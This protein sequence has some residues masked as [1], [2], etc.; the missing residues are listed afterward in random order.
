MAPSFPSI[1]SAHQRDRSTADVYDLSEAEP[2]DTFR[3]SS[4]DGDRDDEQAAYLISSRRQATSST[5]LLRLV[6][7]NKWIVFALIVGV[8]MGQSMRYSDV[9]AFGAVREALAKSVGAATGQEARG[10][11]VA[12]G[13]WEPVYGIEDLSRLGTHVPLKE[14]ALPECERTVLLNWV[15]PSPCLPPYASRSR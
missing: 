3:S 12:S 9:D 6:R 2:L 14:V 11:E 1:P 13:I 10:G 5:P 8:L 7:D 4:S 15:C